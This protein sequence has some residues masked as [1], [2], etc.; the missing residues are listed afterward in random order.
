MTIKDLLKKKEYRGNQSLLAKELNVSRNTL[1]KYI[2]DESG[3]QHIIRKQYG[4][5]VLFTARGNK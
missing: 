3:E 5:Y 2:N 4:S 1:A